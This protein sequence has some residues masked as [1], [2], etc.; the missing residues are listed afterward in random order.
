MK[1]KAPKSHFSSPSL[2]LECL[3]KKFPHLSSLKAFSISIIRQTSKRGD[4][5]KS[6]IS[7]SELILWLTAHPFLLLPHSPTKLS[8]E[9]EKIYLFV[10]SYL[11]P[12]TD[13]LRHWL[14]LPS[15]T[16]TARLSTGTCTSTSLSHRRPPSD[17][18]QARAAREIC[19]YIYIEPEI[20][21]QMPPIH[22]LT[23]I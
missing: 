15:P 13:V 4:E 2:D 23:P 8:C 22:K 11:L 18:D 12:Q 3:S 5:V 6:H 20:L 7:R 17:F 1:S 21:R 9:K 14:R 10:L 19:I 16:L